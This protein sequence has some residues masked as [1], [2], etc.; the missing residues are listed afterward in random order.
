[1][2]T[3]ALKQAIFNCRGRLEIFKEP[4][5]ERHTSLDVE[6]LIDQLYELQELRNIDEETKP[7][8]LIQQITDILQSLER[9]VAPYTGMDPQL[10]TDETKQSLQKSIDFYKNCVAELGLYIHCAKIKNEANDELIAFKSDL[11]AKSRKHLSFFS[12]V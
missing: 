2:A 3:D 5:Y 1:M 7:P 4:R 10:M 8:Q 11:D 12:R 6:S 9:Q